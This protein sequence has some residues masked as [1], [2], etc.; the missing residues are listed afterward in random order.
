MTDF[1]IYCD[2]SRHTSDP[3]QPYLVIGAVQC[4]R[5]SKREIVGRMH[6]LQARYATQGELGWKRVSPNRL[7]FYEALLELFA[8]D[9]VLR[10]RCLVANRNDLD[11]ATYN[12]GD[13]ELGFYK[14]YYQMLMHWLQAGNRYHIYM[15]WQQNAVQSRFS[16]LSLILKRKL[17]G[18]ASI[19]CLEPVNSAKLPL[20]G[21]ADILIGA[22]GYAWNGLE[23]S[24]AK[25]RICEKLRDVA[26]MRT[27][28]TT[29]PLTAHKVNIFRFGGQPRG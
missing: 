11:H 19:A 12:D 26:D 5:D 18:R 10:F 9:P 2:E 15:D 8:S 29:T 4:P 27:L 22:V 28:A 1:N 3:S 13:S 16:D 25:L 24:R 14:L 21:L 20:V 23:G 7:E 6:H 17:S